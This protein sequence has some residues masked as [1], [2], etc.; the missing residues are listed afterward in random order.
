LN[1]WVSIFFKLIIIYKFIYNFINKKIG[2]N[3]TLNDITGIF[4]EE[5]TEKIRT[6]LKKMWL[7]NFYDFVENN[8]SGTSREV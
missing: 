1:H 5:K 4:K 8:L 3:K 7:E 2:E 6:S